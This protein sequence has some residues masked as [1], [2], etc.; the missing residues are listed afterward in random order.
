MVCVGVAG[1]DGRFWT[2]WSSQIGPPAAPT[3]P[4]DWFVWQ[5]RWSRL[6]DGY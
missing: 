3:G 6:S 1:V 2:E 4:T 5:V